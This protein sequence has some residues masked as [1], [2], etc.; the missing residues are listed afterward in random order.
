MTLKEDFRNEII[1]LGFVETLVNRLGRKKYFDDA[2]RGLKALME[3][4][5][6]GCPINI[7]GD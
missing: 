4:C 1:K 7:L 6:W 3:Y 5:E 2:Q